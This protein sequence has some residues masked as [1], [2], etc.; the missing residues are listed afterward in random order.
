MHSLWFLSGSGG[1]N[2]FCI[3]LLKAKEAAT[4]LPLRKQREM[5][6]ANIYG[7]DASIPSQHTQSLQEGTAIH[8]SLHTMMVV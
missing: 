8:Q 6:T 5:N 1:W 7:L 4:E 2:Y 3:L